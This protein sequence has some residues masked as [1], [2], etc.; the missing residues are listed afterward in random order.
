ATEQAA[1]HDETRVEHV[2]QAREAEAEPAADVIDRSERARITRLSVGKDRVD[3]RSAAAGSA[4]GTPQEGIRPD[5][6]LP[7]SDRSASAAGTRR[8]DRDVPDL[9]G[10]ARDAGERPAVDDQPA[11][12]ADFAREQQD[13]LRKH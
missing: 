6:R 13:A 1:E 7:A 12:D 9:A 2:D 4:A 11:T 10:I 5:L 8:I 3:L